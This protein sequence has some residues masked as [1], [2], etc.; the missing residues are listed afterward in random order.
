MWDIPGG[1]VEA[2]EN[3]VDALTRELHEELG[4]AIGIAEVGSAFATID[5]AAPDDLSLVI[6]RIDTWRGTPRN[7][8]PAEHD[9][10]AWFDVAEI[11]EL[12]LAD[13]SYP[14]LLARAVSAHDSQPS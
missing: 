1:H 8:A 9:H 5:R 14:A 10:I 4:I 7:L 6:Y 11:V 3:D 13:A 12:P 2:H